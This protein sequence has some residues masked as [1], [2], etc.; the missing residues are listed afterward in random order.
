[1]DLNRIERARRVRRSRESRPFRTFYDQFRAY[2]EAEEELARSGTSSATKWLLQRGFVISTVTA[3]EV[4]FRDMLD[5]VF[6]TCKPEAFLPKLCEIHKAKYDI[7]DLIAIYVH[8]LHPCELILDG[9][10]FQRVDTIGR[11]F[12]TILGTPFWKS[13]APV[14]VRVK[15]Q[16][17]N[18]LEIKPDAVTKYGQ[19]LQLRHELVHNPEISKKELN[20]EELD[21]LYETPV[22]ILACDLVIMSFLSKNVDPEL[23]LSRSPQAAAPNDCNRVDE[24]SS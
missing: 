24:V 16:P 11:V 17:S 18:V 19:L 14:Q 2:L 9:I 12:S 8:R 15:D 3:T 13:I 21:C 23:E 10:S 7:D 4:Y 5:A 20:E 1:M 6:R 22:L